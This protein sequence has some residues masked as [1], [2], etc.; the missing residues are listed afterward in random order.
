VEIT[1]KLTEIEEQKITRAII[2]KA[3][4]DWLDLSEA[5]VAVVGAG[6]SGLTAA[7][8][9]AAAKLRT[10]IFEKRLSFGGG[11]G[12]G[13]M[14]FHKAVI[15]SPAD[16]ILKDVKCRLDPIKPGVY[17]VDTAEMIAK[18][19]TGAIDSGV[20]II[21]GTMVDDVVYRSPPPQ[22]TGIVVQWTAVNMANLHVDPLA[23]KARAVVDCTGHSAEVLTVASRKVPEFKLTVPGESSMW[24]SRAEEMTLQK[25][26]K[27]CRGL[28]MAGMAAAAL[29]HTP[30]MGPIFGGMLLSGRKVAKLI[31]RDL[32]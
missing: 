8:Y 28:Y 29:H 25:T 1:V 7:R 19:A 21:L 14:L 5:D 20:K 26:G 3:A 30:R 27:A 13:G 22:V 17:T 10:V 16:K 32:T 18:L 23:I 12:G 4:E 24:A 31:I 2:G 6:S 9:L 15:Q 11:M